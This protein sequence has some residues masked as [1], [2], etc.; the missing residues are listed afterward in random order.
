M[1]FNNTRIIPW[2]FTDTI[3][4]LGKITFSSTPS[5]I[6]KQKLTELDL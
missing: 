3:D 1:V 5:E 4:Y 2:T 6:T